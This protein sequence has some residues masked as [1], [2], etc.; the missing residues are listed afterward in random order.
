MEE[1]KKKGKNN[2]FFE[3]IKSDLQNMVL[4]LALELALR[5]LELRTKLVRG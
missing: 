5:N 1:K 3:K 4:K 2:V